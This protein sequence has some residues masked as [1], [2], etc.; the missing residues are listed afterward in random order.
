LLNEIIRNIKR[1]DKISKMIKAA[2]A[3]AHSHP[4]VTEQLSDNRRNKRMHQN[5]VVQK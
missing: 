4:L 2:K 3:E 1:F 5:T